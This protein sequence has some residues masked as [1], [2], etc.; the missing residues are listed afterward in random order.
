MSTSRRD[1]APHGSSLNLSIKALPD[2]VAGVFLV[3]ALLNV[4][5]ETRSKMFLGEVR[6]FKIDSAIDG[7]RQEG[8]NVRQ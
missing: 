6:F 7:L 4:D 5:Q 3:Q 1:P 8:C 2:E